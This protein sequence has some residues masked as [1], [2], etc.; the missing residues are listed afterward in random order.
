MLARVDRRQPDP[1]RLAVR[2]ATEADIP[3]L[4]S[5]EDE[6]FDAWYYRPHRFREAQFR[7]YLRRPHSVLVVAELQSSVVGYIAGSSRASRPQ[8]SARIDSVA[9]LPSSQSKG[10]GERLLSC[11][12]QAARERG[13]RTVTLEV[14]LANEKAI[15]FF[16]KRGFRRT[17]RLPSYYGEGVDGMRM[18][19]TLSREGVVA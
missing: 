8:P 3:G 7:A 5:L 13:C 17:R 19:L 11:F 10:V 18:Q 1:D 2:P 15:S 4:V 16:A 14:A 6:C 9:V 12:L